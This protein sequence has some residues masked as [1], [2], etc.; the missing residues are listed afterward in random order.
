MKVV[1]LH[2]DETVYDQYKRE[3]R[4]RRRSASELIREAMGAYLEEMVAPDR[5]SLLDES[6]PARVGEIFSLP[7]SRAELFDDF[8]ERE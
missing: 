8:L 6:V 4:L 7:N 1:T 2:I 3:A 5:A